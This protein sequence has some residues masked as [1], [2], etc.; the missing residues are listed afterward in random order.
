MPPA[1]TAQAA[2]AA[3]APAR[4]QHSS[5]VTGQLRTQ[6]SS[7]RQLLTLVPVSVALGVVQPQAAKAG[8]QSPDIR[9]RSSL[10][11]CPV[12]SERHLHCLDIADSSSRSTIL[13][14]HTERPRSS[15]LSKQAWMS[16][17]GRP[18]REPCS[19]FGAPAASRDG[20]RHALAAWTHAGWDGPSRFLKSRQQ[21]NA[22]KLMAP[23]S[24]SL[25]R[26]Q[27]CRTYVRDRLAQ[28]QRGHARRDSGH[29]LLAIVLSHCGAWIAFD[30]DFICRKCK[31]CL[32]G[33]AQVAPTALT[34]GAA[35]YTALPS[36]WSAGHPATATTSRPLA[37]IASRRKY[38]S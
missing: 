34:A 36:P 2:K 35:R 31:A 24:V 4:M 21:A 5:S 6:A 32:K 26:L 22:S 29:S 3:R 1:R 18:P 25:Q 12:N 10:Q 19:C 15:F 8:A 9:D 27:V 17:E 23:F 20:T 13:D 7:R 33:P 38:P 14:V 11:G 28:R 37:A 16:R 30:T